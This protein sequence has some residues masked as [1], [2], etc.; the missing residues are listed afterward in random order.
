MILLI[1]PSLSEIA[2][3]NGDKMKIYIVCKLSTTKIF[4]R[5]TAATA[6]VIFQTFA[7]FY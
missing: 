5:I 3:Y 1:F 2:V 6:N 4:I 7:H